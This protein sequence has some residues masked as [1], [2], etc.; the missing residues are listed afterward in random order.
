MRVYVIL[1]EEQAEDIDFS[2][3]LERDENG[4]RWNNDKSKT[5]VKYEGSK[6]DFL[7]GKD[8]LTHAQILTELENEE[9]QAP[10]PPE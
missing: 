5:F 3:V 6:P 10:N 2:K 1:T 4:L 9:W 8:A 7:I